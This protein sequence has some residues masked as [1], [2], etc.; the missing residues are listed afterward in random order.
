MYFWGLDS[1]GWGNGYYAAAAQAGATDWK[2]F[3][4]GASDGGNGITVDKLP[5][6]IWLSSLSLRVFG[7]S[8]WS[9]LGPQALL[10]VGTVALTYFTVRRHFHHNSAMIAGVVL[11]LTPAAVVMFRYNNPDAL[12]IFLLTLA[13]Y[14]MIRAA[15]DGR[16]RWVLATGGVI[17]AAFLTKSAQA[18]LLFPVLGG[19]YLYA[20]PG[21]FNRR[22]RQLASCV[23]VAAAIAGLWIMTAELTSP[24]ARPYA[25]GSFTNSF[26]E[27]LLRQNGLGR[28]LGASGGGTPGSEAA[29][30]GPFRLIRYASFGSQGV[31]L[32]PAAALLLL[33]S[34]I[35]LRRQPRCDKRRAILL[36]SGGWMTIYW[37]TFSL[38]GGVVHPY[39]LATLAPAGAILAGAVNGLITPA[40]RWLPYRIA[41]SL[42]VL[43]CGI[44]AFGY[45]T[46]S[47]DVGRIFA[48]IVA[49][50]CL[51]SCELIV[52]RLR[53]RSVRRLTASSVALTCGLGPLLLSASAVISPHTGV[54][55]T[56]A[57]V[58]SPIV[59][60]S[61]D[62]TRW[63]AGNSQRIRG[64]ALGHPADPDVLAFLRSTGDRG[65]RWLAATPGALNAAQYQLNLESPV[66][67]VGG[68]NGSTPYPTTG[69]LADYIESGEIRFY[70]VRHDSQDIE[71]EAEYAD[72][73]TSWVR[74][75]YSY[76]QVGAMDVF[77]FHQ[78]LQDS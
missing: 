12:L 77:D 47:S 66:M 8:S 46:N 67:P 17:G 58:G 43:I 72:E 48:L 71:P 53:N 21:P 42:S 63:P 19:V 41:L 64:S 59:L 18:L 39:Y 23:A 29:P 15:E 54:S 24:D 75:H 49:A 57:L 32:L 1:N 70:I 55:P 30:P 74:S 6:S 35:L 3:F 11:L 31:W 38:M 36:A 33:A 61:P 34:L 51:I 50:I 22:L 62:P 4:F 52:F 40:Q 56:A 28:I 20:G 14:L 27:V 37:T 10:G 2:A 16:W 13:T 68:F 44:L 73:V 25:G 69:Q 45:L 5:A 7:L 9:L 26:V 60:D 78:Q 65:S 76:I